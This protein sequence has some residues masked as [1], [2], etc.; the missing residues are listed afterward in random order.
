MISALQHYVYCPRR[1]ALIHLEQTFTDN[2]HTVRGQLA[3]ARVDTRDAETRE[4]LRTERALALYSDTLGL[5]GRADV[6]EFQPDGTPYPVEHK[7]G[8]QA[9]PHAD[10]VQLCA[11]ALCLEEML[12]F[13]VP[14]GAIYHVRT[15]RRREVIFTAELRAHVRHTVAAVRQLLAQTDLPAPHYD[16]RC[17]ACS[18]I[19][20]CQPQVLERLQ[21][22]T[23]S[24]Y[25][26]EDEP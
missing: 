17:R 11:Q 5:V 13:P 10:E 8:A 4:G 14:C 19:D 25:A 16:A 12:G 18:L 23:D 26:L 1:C 7:L 9:A 21:S 15:R 2:I 22:A 6:V 24:L 3:H 20:V